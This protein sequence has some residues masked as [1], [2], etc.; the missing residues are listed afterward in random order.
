MWK[1]HPWTHQTGTLGG[2]RRRHSSIQRGRKWRLH[3]SEVVVDAVREVVAEE[4]GAKD[5]VRPTCVADGDGL[6]QP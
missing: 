5:D 4:V 3:V 6:E 2:R 1:R